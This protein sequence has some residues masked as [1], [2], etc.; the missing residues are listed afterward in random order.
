M[1]LALSSDTS[2]NIDFILDF[3]LVD[4]SA[5]IAFDLNSTYI[6]PSLGIYVFILSGCH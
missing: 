1:D 3:I 2:F 5:L 6:V 4:A